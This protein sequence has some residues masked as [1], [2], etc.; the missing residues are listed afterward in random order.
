MITF[1]PFNSARREYM[2]NKF[3]AKSADSS[4]P[5]PPRISTI[6]FFVSLGSFGNNRTSNSFSKILI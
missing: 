4:P 6:T 5:A 2:R 1:Q 3:A